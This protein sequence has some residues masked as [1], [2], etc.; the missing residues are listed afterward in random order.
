VFDELEGAE[1]ALTKL[2]RCDFA[3]NPATVNGATM[4]IHGN[5]L[6]LTAV[7]LEHRPEIDR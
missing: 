1:T 4:A 7:P 6:G 5:V 2:K 3:A